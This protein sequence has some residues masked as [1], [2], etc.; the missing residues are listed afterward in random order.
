MFACVHCSYMNVFL[1]MSAFILLLVTW[2][3]I[4]VCGSF[5][6]K[7]GGEK[8]DIGNVQIVY[9]LFSMASFTM[10]SMLE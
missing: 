6:R 1:F 3:L 8:G 9:Q 5:E 4:V 2:L 7:K 10:Q